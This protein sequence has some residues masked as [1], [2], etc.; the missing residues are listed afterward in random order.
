MITR[1]TKE[2]IKRIKCTWVQFLKALGETTNA[3]ETSKNITIWLVICLPPTHLSD[4]CLLFS[5]FRQLLFDL[6]W[7]F[8]PTLPC[9]VVLDQTVE[10]TMP[11]VCEVSSTHPT[12]I[13][14]TTQAT[15]Q[16]TDDATSCPSCKQ[17]A[18]K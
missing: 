18:N 3:D 11:L 2:K 8:L 17:P 10:L 5:F 13:Q 15:V 16:R 1:C 9:A 4:W 6:L 12:V 7:E 14:P